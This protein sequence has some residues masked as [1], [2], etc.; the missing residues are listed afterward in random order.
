MRLQI[1]AR[2]VLSVLFRRLRDPV[3]SKMVGC[4]RRTIAR[5]LRVLQTAL[6]CATARSR[7]HAPRYVFRLNWR[8]NPSI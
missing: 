5:E 4:V 1:R 7:G 6:R 8:A 2:K 3:L